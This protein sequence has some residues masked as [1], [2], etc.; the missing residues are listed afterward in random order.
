[1]AERTDLCRQYSISPVKNLSAVSL[2]P[3]TS[4]LAVS[5]TLA[6]NLL[7]VSLTPA[8]TFFPDVVG[9]GQK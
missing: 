5:L 2:A 8:I 4:L 7:A 9:A 6:N 1:L 3:V